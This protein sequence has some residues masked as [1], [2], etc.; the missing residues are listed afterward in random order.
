MSLVRFGSDRFPMAKVRLFP[1]SPVC[2]LL[3]F[4]LE[5]VPVLNRFRYQ[6]NVS[7]FGCG[8]GS[9][10]LGTGEFPMM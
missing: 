6:K 5:A 10:A 4:Y 1:V 8:S 2:K 9:V 3:R 7:R